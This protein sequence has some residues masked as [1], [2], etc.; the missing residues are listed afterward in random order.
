MLWQNPDPDGPGGQALKHGVPVEQSHDP[1]CADGLVAGQDPA[2]HARL[3]LS[4]HEL[5]DHG[6]QEPAAAHPTQTRLASRVEPPLSGKK[7]SGSVS[8]QRASSRHAS[9]AVAGA[10]HEGLRTG[11]AAAAAAAK[12]SASRVRGGRE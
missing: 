10:I 9:S 12:E 7:A 1:W 5:G 2:D 3:D 8:A 11:S 6:R 4:L